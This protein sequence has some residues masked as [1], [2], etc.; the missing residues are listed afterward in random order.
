VGRD[1]CTLITV[2][3]ADTVA[4]D[5]SGPARAGGMNEQSRE[6]RLNSRWETR[7]ALK[8]RLLKSHDS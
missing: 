8:S 3:Y 4:L 2:K 7:S 6:W 1:C 5:H